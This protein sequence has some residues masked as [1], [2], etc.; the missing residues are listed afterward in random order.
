MTDWVLP[1]RD[2]VK[3]IEEM[4]DRYNNVEPKDVYEERYIVPGEKLSLDFKDDAERWITEIFYDFKENS[5]V[6]LFGAGH[7]YY[8]NYFLKQCVGVNKFY[9]V[10]FVDAS[11]KGLDKRIDFFNTDILK[12]DLPVSCDYIFTTH[13]LEHFTKPEIFDVVLPRFFL[14]AKKAIVIVVP[15]GNNWPNEPNHK[16]RFYENDELAALSSRYKIIR[17]GAEIVYWINRS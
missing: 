8:S 1:K 2:F 7:S 6:L 12:E 10:D 9:A 4:I 11:S 5:F 16:C 17:G 3:P 15:Y 14:A 13:T